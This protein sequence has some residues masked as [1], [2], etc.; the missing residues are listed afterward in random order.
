[1]FG[2]RA[3]PGYSVYAACKAA[4]ISFTKTAALEFGAH[5][6]RVNVIAPDLI[7]TPGLTALGEAAQE[8]ARIRDQL[9]SPLGRSASIDEAGDVVAFLASDLASYVTGVTIPVDRAGPM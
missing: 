3:A 9:Y 6:I 7:V 8:Q 2:L 1:M 4:I 5:G